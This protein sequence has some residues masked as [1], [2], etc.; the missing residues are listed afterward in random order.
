MT[1]KCKASE[2]RS[3]E[4]NLDQV[5]VMQIMLLSSWLL[6]QLKYNLVG[7]FCCLSYLARMET[8]PRL[9]SNPRRITEYSINCLNHESEESNSSI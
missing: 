7:F 8:F 3:D 5:V 4:S 9:A 2:R 1:L 6:M